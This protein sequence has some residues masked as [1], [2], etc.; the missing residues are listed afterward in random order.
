MYTFPHVSGKQYTTDRLHLTNFVV[1]FTVQL[2]ALVFTAMET[3]RSSLEHILLS[4]LGA[5]KN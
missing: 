2:P 3:L 4:L 5:E 1:W